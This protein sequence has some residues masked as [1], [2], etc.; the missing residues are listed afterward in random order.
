MTKYNSIMLDLETMATSHDAAIVSIGMFKFNLNEMQVYENIIEPQKFKRNISLESAQKAGLKID[1]K[2]VE[3]WMDQSDAA[4]EGMKGFM[5][6]ADVLFEAHSFMIAED[7]EPR[8]LLWGN[9][10]TF[11]NTILRNAFKAV[12]LIFPCPYRVDSCYRT[13]NR[14]FGDE[15]LFV[16]YGTHHNALD[17]AISQALCLQKIV[18]SIG[19]A[20][21]VHA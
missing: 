16:R 4:R 2:T 18:F 15:R 8:Y 10:P 7:M 19:G 6:L 5:P 1:G 3:W 9:A 12:D 20:K 14:L 13:M 11:D 17:D 21:N